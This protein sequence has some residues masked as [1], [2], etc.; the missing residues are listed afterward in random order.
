MPNN[1]SSPLSEHAKVLCGRCGATI[2]DYPTPN[3]KSVAL[4]NAVGR[5]VII[6]T[7]AYEGGPTDGYQGHWDH[8]KDPETTNRV[9]NEEFLWH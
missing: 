6:G 2:W 1:Q 3:G 9:S 5:Y 4:D 8:C 7:H